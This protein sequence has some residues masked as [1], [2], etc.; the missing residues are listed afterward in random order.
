MLSRAHRRSSER[1][2]WG[3]ARNPD[4][5]EVK[6]RPAAVLDTEGTHLF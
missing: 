6:A 4:S 2:D 5:G 1:L 3:S